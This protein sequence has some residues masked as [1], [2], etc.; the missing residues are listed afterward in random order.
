MEHLDSAKI[1]GLPRNPIINAHI[2]NDFLDVQRTKGQPDFLGFPVRF[3]QFWEILLQMGRHPVFVSLIGGD[4][5]WR[6]RYYLNVLLWYLGNPSIMHNI[7]VLFIYMISD[8]KELGK[9]LA[10]GMVWISGNPIASSHHSVDPSSGS[11][12]WLLAG[13]LTTLPPDKHI[14]LNM[15]VWNTPNDFC[16]IQYVKVL[17]LCVF[18]ELTEWAAHPKH[19]PCDFVSGNVQNQLLEGIWPWLCPMK[20]GI[21]PQICLVCGSTPWETQKLSLGTI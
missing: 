10:H 20:C 14:C 21:L 19:S 16:P 18:W 9:Y 13:F 5:L 8:P 4:L 15:L 3:T 7:H 11:P 17:T 12:T 1:D 6:G 2:R